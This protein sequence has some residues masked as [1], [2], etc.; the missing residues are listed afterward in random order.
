MKANL[1]AKVNQNYKVTLNRKSQGQG[2]GLFSVHLMTEIQ[3]CSQYLFNQIFFSQF[4]S[5]ISQ[6]QRSENKLSNG[7]IK[8]REN[9]LLM[10]M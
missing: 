6:F 5:Q 7:I 9:A 2:P 4:L 8:A 3:L 1:N 10:G